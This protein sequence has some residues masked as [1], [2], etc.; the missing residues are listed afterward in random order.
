MER[1]NNIKIVFLDI[2]G[3]L[4][5]SKK[6]VTKKSKEAIKRIVSKGIKVVLV[7]GRNVPY[8]IDVS[9]KAFASP[10]VISSNGAEIYD[11]EN[12]ELL[13]GDRIP[14]KKIKEV[15][16]FCNDNKIKVIF[17]TIDSVYANKYMI[18]YNNRDYKEI[19]NKN[20]LN[21]L[22]VIQI[23]FQLANSKEIIQCKDLINK[24]DLK[25]NYLPDGFSDDKLNSLDVNN[26]EVSKGVAIKYLLKLFGIKKE[27]SLCIGD[28]INDKDM[29]KVCGYKVAMMN[30]TLDIKEIS[31]FITL[32]NDDNGVAEFIDKYL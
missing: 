8:A 6:E 13:Y 18:D 9:K 16:E 1:L 23:T 29:F 7:T 32:S 5:N 24:L 21:K 11:Y 31:D 22:V 15:Y 30:A 10:I 3:T 12:K 17:N 20:E 27:E 2:D 19:I 14:N 28:Y 26:Q 4:T 25:I